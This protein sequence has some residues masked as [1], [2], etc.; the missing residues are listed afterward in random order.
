MPGGRIPDNWGLIRKL[1][2]QWGNI[3]ARYVVGLRPIRDCTAGFRA[4]H[5]SILKRLDLSTLKVKGYVF[6]VALLSQL[7]Y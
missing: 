1:L 7:R 6:Q 5:A 3:F 4:I 2:S